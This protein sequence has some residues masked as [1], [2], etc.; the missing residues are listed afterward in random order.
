MILA[1]SG[2]SSVNFLKTVKRLKLHAL[3]GIRSNRKLIDGR[4][5][6]DL[7][8]GGQQIYL[9]DLPF[10]VSVAHYYFKQDNGKYL[11]RYVICTKQ[12][13]ASTL[14]WWGKKRWQIE[15]FFKTIK[16]R[17]SLHCF[18]QETKLGVD[19]WLILSFLSFVLAYAT[20]C[21][22]L[23]GATELNWRIAAQKTWEILFPSVLLNILLRDIE[24]LEPIANQHGIAVQ[25]QRC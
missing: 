1:D 2:F 14:V 13:K 23:G 10:P 21:F 19:R 20:Y 6:K 7:H 3:V 8:K 9:V 24:R 15:G 11:K 22:E 5:I 16:H 18:G 25:I 12:L 17:F 4:K